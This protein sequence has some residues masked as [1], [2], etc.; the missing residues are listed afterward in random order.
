M[1]HPFP[2]INPWMEQHWPDVH[3]RLLTGLADQLSERLPEDLAARTEEA[4]AIK[5]DDTERAA[6]PDI[7]VTE[8]WREGRPPVWTPTGE[9]TVGGIIAEPVLVAVEPETQRWL[10]IRHRDGRLVT[11]IEILSPSNKR[12]GSGHEAYRERQSACLA[13]PANLVEIDFLRGGWEATR[14]SRHQL[15]PRAAGEVSLAC[16]SRAR[17][18][19]RAEVYAFPLR[20]P[21]PAFRIPLRDED[22]DVVVE[23]QPLL[24]RCYRTG[25]Y[26]QLDYARPLDPPLSPE[27][28]AWAEECLRQAGLR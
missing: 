1:K 6:R 8:S 10:E 3:T 19:W 20:Q 23:L 25:R 28:A 9:G 16:V 26:W 12:R 27:D 5:E 17:A 24:E 14:A 18:P 15:G 11:A 22:A 2:G 7:A 21:I 13:G 4:L